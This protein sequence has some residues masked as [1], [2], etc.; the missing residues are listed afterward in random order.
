V[1]L[2]QLF[3]Q[4]PGDAPPVAGVTVGRTD[5]SHGLRGGDV[6]VIRVTKNVLER[7]GK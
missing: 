7:L 3:R 2:L 4:Q 6:N 1:D 5:C